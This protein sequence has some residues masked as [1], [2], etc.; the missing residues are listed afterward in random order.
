LARE[1]VQASGRELQGPEPRTLTA[2]FAIGNQTDD[3]L[4]TE[5]ELIRDWMARRTASSEAEDRLL[6]V[7]ATAGHVLFSRHPDI[8]NEVKED[9]GDDSSLIALAPPITRTGVIQAKKLAEV[10]KAVPRAPAPGPALAPE[11]L[12]PSGAGAGGAGVSLVGLAGWAFLIFVFFAPRG[13]YISPEQQQRIADAISF[14]A[15]KTRTAPKPEP[16][17]SPK[18]KP[19]DLPPTC[20]Q[21]AKKLSG[22]SRCNFVAIDPKSLPLL[23]YNEQRNPQASVYCGS[24]TNDEPCEY[25]L[26]PPRGAPGL[27]APWALFDAFDG[28][29]LIECKCGYNDFVDHADETWARNK[30]NDLLGQLTRHL[31]HARTC[32]WPY[33]VIVS[34]RKLQ[35][36]I[37]LHGP[38]GLDIEVVESDICD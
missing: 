12:G 22:E 19:V 30:L 6:S 28:A 14:A 2:E 26:Y 18:P 3:W 8:V 31:D 16:R 7:L 35:E 1:P 24:V 37:R 10:A 9:T 20:V 15:S 38:H 11:A 32:G 27:V 21:N 5:I 13:E 34:S 23:A 33:R 4:I 25:A 17:P 36:Y 29:S